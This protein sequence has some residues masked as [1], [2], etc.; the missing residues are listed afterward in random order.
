MF[1][2]PL[3]SCH[4]TQWSGGRLDST[5]ASPPNRTIAIA[6]D[7]SKAFDT[8]SHRLIIEMIHLSW[9]CHNL[10]RWLVAYLCGRKASCLYQQYHWSFR[11]VWAGVPQESVN[12]PALFNFF[13][14]DCPFPDL[15]M[16]SYAD[17]FALLA[18]APSIVEAEVRANQLCTILVSWADG[19]QLA[20]APKKSSVTLFTLDPPV[21]TPPSSANRRRSDSVEQIPKIL[22]VTLDPHFTFGP[23]TRDCVEWASRAL[24]IMKALAGSSWGFTTETLVATNK[25]IVLPILNHAAPIWFTQISSSHLDKLEVIQNKNPGVTTRC[26]QK[27]VASHLRAE[28]G[29]LTLKV[30]L[31]LCC[32]QFYAS[33]LPPLQI[34]LIPFLHNPH[35]RC[36]PPPPWPPTGPH[37]PHLTLHPTSSHPWSGGHLPPPPPLSANQQQPASQL[38]C[39]WDAETG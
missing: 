10:V 26:H 16:T 38:P 35:S 13:V 11:Q 12:S 24:N 21:P 37:H 31:E 17:D 5:N 4:F 25:A 20:I 18:S 1:I 15:D 2:P 39:S 7:I 36:W 28:T 19:K 9:L 8:V 22:G 14:S 29:V 30:H 23:L 3:T 34:D 33:D 27:A 32:Q 6:V